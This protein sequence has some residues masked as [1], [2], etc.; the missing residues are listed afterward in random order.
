[1]NTGQYIVN[2]L[3]CRGKTLF[4]KLRDVPQPFVCICL[5]KPDGF[6][7]YKVCSSCG[8]GAWWNRSTIFKKFEC[9][10]CKSESKE[11]RKSTI[12][13]Y[14]QPWERN[15]PN[16]SINWHEVQKKKKEREEAKR[17]AERIELA[18]MIAEKLSK[19]IHPEIIVNEL[20]DK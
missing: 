9:E 14:Q 3:L 4:E 16:V 20:E 15:R 7:D 2:C 18:E 10:Y 5:S 11:N 12:K 6:T 1:M 19:R 17:R 8:K 13:I